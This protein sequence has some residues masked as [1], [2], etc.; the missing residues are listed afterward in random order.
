MSQSSNQVLRGSTLTLGASSTKGFESSST[1][2]KGASTQGADSKEISDVCA[3]RPSSGPP[4]TPD[5]PA[6]SPPPDGGRDAWLAVL[7]GWCAFLVSFGWLNS[8][9]VF[10]EYYQQVPLHDYT[11]SAVSWIPSTEIFFLFVGGPIIG[12]L[13]DSY[14]PRYLLLVGS[15]LHVFGLMMCSLATKYYQFFL[16]QSVCSAIGCSLIFYSAMNAAS[17]WF[18]KKRAY[19]LGIIA[20]GSSLGG[21]FLPIMVTKLIPRVGFGWTMRAIAFVFLGLLVVANVT[22]TSRL[23]HTS[24]SFMVMEFIIP[25]RELPF[26]LLALASFFFYFGVFLPINFLI[27]QAQTEGISYELSNYLVPIMNAAR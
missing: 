2:E 18:M 14:G 12:K 26:A 4:P 9:G 13:F 21:V 24:R 1:L 11:P 17:T 19:A 15:F 6:V 25:L 23:N 5:L 8:V 22:V 3:E 16:A 27:V 10:Q 20:S 7:G